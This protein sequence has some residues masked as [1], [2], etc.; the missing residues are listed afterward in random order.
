MNANTNE[1]LKI[2]NKNVWKMHVLKL[3]YTFAIFYTV[4]NGKN[5]LNPFNIKLPEKQNRNSCCYYLI[6]KMLLFHLLPKTVKFKINEAIF[7]IFLYSFE[8]GSLALS[9][10]S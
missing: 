10:R 1:V 2:A 7:P 8:T 3:K 9:K 6:Q 4:N 5:S